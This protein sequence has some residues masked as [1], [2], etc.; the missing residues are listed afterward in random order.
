RAVGVDEEV[1]RHLP[2]PDANRRVAPRAHGF[3]R[4]GRRTCDNDT[5]DLAPSERSPLA[6]GFSRT[7]SKSPPTASTNSPVFE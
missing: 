7:R 6:V 3:G 5:H 2:V 4:G 1:D